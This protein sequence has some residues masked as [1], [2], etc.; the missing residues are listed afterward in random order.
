[1]PLL[2]CLAPSF[3]YQQRAV[4][5]FKINLSI[6]PFIPGLF[7]FSATAKALE[8]SGAI[9]FEGT[10]LAT[11]TECL[12]ERLDGNGIFLSNYNRNAT[13]SHNEMAWIGGTAMAAWGSTGRCLDSECSRKLSWDVGPDVRVLS[14]L[15]H[16]YFRVCLE[17][18][19][20]CC[21]VPPPPHCPCALTGEDGGAPPH[22]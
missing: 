14:L 20:G 4:P 9:L 22:Q 7:C 3:R 17:G 8:R 1:M 13:L 15:S 2:N 18:S 10:E 21:S 16:R 12:F 5:F 11:V 19:N 6:Y